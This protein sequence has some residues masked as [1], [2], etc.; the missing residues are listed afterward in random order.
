MN[1]LSSYRIQLKITKR[2]NFSNREHD[3]E[4]PQMFPNVL[5]RL[6]LTSKES[7]LTFEVVELN[8]SGK[9]VEMR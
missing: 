5:K 6:Q 8:T 9:K 3:C 4:G 7:P 2:T 1:M